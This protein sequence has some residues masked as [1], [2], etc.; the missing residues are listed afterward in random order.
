MFF[1]NF[2]F[3]SFNSPMP[4]INKHIISNCK[5]ILFD[6]FYV[7]FVNIINQIV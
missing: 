5:T 1:I 6:I 2:S 7:I 4:T 3:L